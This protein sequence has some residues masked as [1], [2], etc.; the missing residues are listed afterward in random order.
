[1]RCPFAITYANL[2]LFPLFAT[3]PTQELLK[4]V[5]S[6]HNDARPF[7]VVPADVVLVRLDRII[8]DLDL[9]F[10]GTFFVLLCRLV[11]FVC[12]LATCGVGLARSDIAVVRGQIALGLR[13]FLY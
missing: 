1:M 7:G 9:G 2:D 13:R 8:P 3:F 12:T 5:K 4:Q 6:C 10:Y 11:G